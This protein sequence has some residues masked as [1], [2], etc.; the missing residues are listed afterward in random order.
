MVYKARTWDVA[1]LY[2]P[3]HASVPSALD[4]GHEWDHLSGD[5]VGGVGGRAWCVYMPRDH[6]G[7][8]MSQ[9]TNA[10]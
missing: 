1:C 10:L 8:P 6:C 7:G 2:D 5:P 4:R 3:I 9:G